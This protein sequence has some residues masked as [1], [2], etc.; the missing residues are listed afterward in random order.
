[1]F[2]EDSRGKWTIAEWPCVLLL[3]IER[4]DWLDSGEDH[5]VAHK[6]V[7][8]KGGCCFWASLCKS[9]NSQDKRR[10][11]SEARLP[12][13]APASQD[14]VERKDV[15]RAVYLCSLEGVGGQATT[16]R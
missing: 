15:K 8:H 2:L 10:G 5:Q 9:T 3:C 6:E 12:E 11:E 7:V 4:K 16:N 14:D 1:M 13:A